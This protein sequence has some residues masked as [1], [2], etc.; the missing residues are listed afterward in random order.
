[1][2]EIKGKYN[3]AIVYTDSLEEQARV[4]IEEMCNQEFLKQSKIRIMSDVHAGAGCTIGTT[5]TLTDS[6]VPHFV[7]VDIGCGMH[8]SKLKQKEIDLRKLD[9]IIYKYIP[10]GKNVR[11]DIY[12]KALELK[13][14][15]LRCAKYV[16]IHRGYHSIGTLGGGN[17]FIEVNKDDE[18]TL[19]LVI[20]SGSRHLGLEVANYYQRQALLSLNNITQKD[21]ESLIKT[22][23]EEGRQKEIQKTLDQIKETCKEISKEKMGF[24][25]GQYFEDYLHDM[26]IMQEF[27]DL[28]R[29]V[30]S[31]IICNEMKLDVLESF[32]TIHNYIDLE[33]MIL[34]KGAVSARKDEKLIIPMNMKD[35]SLICIGKGN[36]DWNQSAPHGAGRIMS[37]NQARKE[38]D[39]KEYKEIMKDIY[40]SCISEDT[41]DE[42]PL[43]YKKMED[44]I[45]NIHDTVD[46]IKII[47]PIYNFKASE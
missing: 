33:H 20:H 38:L 14:N 39:L 4:Q 16:N 7:G 2:I 30:M 8:V 13:L 43:A 10:S 19:Y 9:E 25:R 32:T 12:E 22:M 24:V 5:M 41:I 26:N 42:C 40:S 46:I 11:K 17:H 6:V 47:K 29:I 18:G 31:G 37:R 3:T 23:K 27:A 34:R 28:N 1:M 35:G 45:K 44:I 21:V 36:D 15:E